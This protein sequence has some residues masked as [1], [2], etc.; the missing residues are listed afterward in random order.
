MITGIEVDS[1]GC[2]GTNCFGNGGWRE[3]PQVFAVNQGNTLR[4]DIVRTQLQLP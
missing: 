4:A 1:D 2:W 3:T